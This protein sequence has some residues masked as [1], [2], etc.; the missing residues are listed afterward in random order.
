MLRESRQ[1]ENSDCADRCESQTAQTG[2]ARYIAA[3]NSNVRL[4]DV[5]LFDSTTGA[6]VVHAQFAHAHQHVQ[7]AETLTMLP[8]PG[9]IGDRS[10]KHV[11]LLVVAPALLLFWSRITRIYENGYALGP[12]PCA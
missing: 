2:F 11:P 4:S 9:T 1:R 7:H 6:G 10:S 12:D 5:S 3:A 8:A